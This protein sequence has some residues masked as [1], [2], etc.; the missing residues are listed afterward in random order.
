MGDFVK[1]FAPEGGVPVEGYPFPC[2]FPD[3]ARGAHSCVAAR[4][5][6]S[7]SLMRSPASGFTLEKLR[8]CLNWIVLVAS[9]TAKR[10]NLSE[11]RLPVGP[12]LIRPL[13][14]EAFELLS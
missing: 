8:A 11:A 14:V 1:R 10:A 6:V 13:R 7:T 5:A 4:N 9:V 12:D 3:E 2:L